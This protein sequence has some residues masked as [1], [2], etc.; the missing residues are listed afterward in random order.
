MRWVEGE[1]VELAGSG[2]GPLRLL[3]SL[4]RGLITHRGGDARALGYVT[5]RKRNWDVRQ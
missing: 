5:E 3:F 1:L 2:A 4:W